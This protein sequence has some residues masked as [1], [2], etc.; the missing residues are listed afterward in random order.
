MLSY[1]RRFIR[2]IAKIAQPLH[3][4]TYKGAM[5]EWST[6]CEEAFK[7]LKEWLATPPVLAYPSFDVDFTLETDASI[8]GL[9]AILS[10][11]QVD[12]NLHPVAYASRALNKAEKNYSITKLETLA[13]L[14]AVSHFHSY[15]YGNKVTVLTDHSAVKTIL[16]TP[17]PTGK[18]ARWWTKIYGWGVK[19]LIIKYWAGRENKVL[20][21][22][23]LEILHQCGIGQDEFQVA[24]V[25]SDQDLSTTLEADPVQTSEGVTDY[26]SE[27]HKDQQLKEIV[28]FLSSGRLPED[29]KRA[30]IVA[31]QETLFSLVD[32]ILYYVDPKSNQQR[33]AVLQ[34]LQKQLLEENHCGLYGGHF[35]G[36]K[37][38]SALVKRWWWRGMYTDVLAY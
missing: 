9:G 31:S 3:D 15:L 38:Y 18:H 8:Q 19:E 29:S 7:L 17:N 13:V 20:S 6:G 25:R 37:L 34:Y 22:V 26:A 5:F 24:V 32:G 23:A 33:V 27:Q 28:D 4:L 14:W 1:Y 36:P 12:G 30:K 21:L 10:Q 11:L 35:S 16:E 2:N